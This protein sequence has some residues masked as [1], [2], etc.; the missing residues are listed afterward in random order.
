[1][2][3]PTTSSKVRGEFGLLQGMKQTKVPDYVVPLIQ[4]TSWLHIINL[5]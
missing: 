2:V 1:M 4:G 5:L 3:V